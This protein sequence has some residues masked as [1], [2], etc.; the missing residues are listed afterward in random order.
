MEL[1]LAILIALG[2]SVTSSDYD[3]Y[4][5]ENPE[6]IERAQYIVD[7]DLYYK[8]DGGGVVVEEGID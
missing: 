8:K 4:S 7:N 3:K 2:Y 6:H 5:Y 1:L